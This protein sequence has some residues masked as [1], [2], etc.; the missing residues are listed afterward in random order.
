VQLAV[1][2]GLAGLLTGCL[3]ESAVGLTGAAIPRAYLASPVPERPI[4]ASKDAADSTIHLT[5]GDWAPYSGAALTHN[6]CDAWVVSE[7]FAR[8]GITVEYAFFPWAR[9]YQLAQSGVFDGTL[10]WGDTSSHRGSFYLSA[11]FISDQ[12]LVFFYRKDHP[13]TYTGLN[14]LGGKLVGMTSGYVYQDEFN[15]DRETGLIKVEEA[16]SDEAN[17][18]KLLAGR[19]DVFPL[20]QLVGNTILANNFTPA[21]NSQITHS[22][23]FAKFHPY[24]LLTKANPENAARMALFDE[25]FKQLKA[26]GRYAEIMQT[27]AP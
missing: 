16:S 8:Q 14:G 5:N 7:A 26:S 20:E 18:R 9:G 23:P 27:C 10:E 2:A 4:N 3:G 1:L 19:I 13:F 25:G 11:D 15:H 21:E 6:G 17:L 22:A 12:N 24:V